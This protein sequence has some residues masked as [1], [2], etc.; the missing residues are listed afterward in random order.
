MKQK[1]E[2]ES[3]KRATFQ[4]WNGAINTYCE[5]N[6]II[7]NIYNNIAKDMMYCLEANKNNI[8]ALVRVDNNN[9]NNNNYKGPNFRVH[10]TI[11]DINE[12]L[13]TEQARA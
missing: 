1:I 3:D 13:Y 9:N 2:R 10:D 11:K 4:N 8:Q 5:M 12:S 6:E 7:I